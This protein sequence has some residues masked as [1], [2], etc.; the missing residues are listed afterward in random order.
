M[1]KQISKK[2]CLVLDLVNNHDLI[3]EYKKF[4]EKV[5]PGIEQSIKGF[6]IKF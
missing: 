4:H 5:W 3:A 6:G 2:Y 1:E